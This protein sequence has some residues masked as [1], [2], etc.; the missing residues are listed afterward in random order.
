MGA[1]NWMPMSFSPLTGLVYIPAMHFPGL[2]KSN[3]ENLVGGVDI[4]LYYA[5]DSDEPYRGELLAWDPVGQQERWRRTIG[6]PYQGGTMVTAGGLVFQGTTKGAFHAYDAKSGKELWSFSTG[7]AVLGAPSTVEIDG[8]QMIF[9]AVGTGTTA[10][11][12][13]APD[14]AD[15]A[16]G[17]ARLLAFS[18][19]GSASLPVEKREPKKLAEPAVGE[20]APALAAK[21]KLI[22]DANGCELCHG[23]QAIGGIGSFPS[24]ERVPALDPI[25]FLAIVRHGVFTASGMPEF[26]DHIREEDVPALQAYITQQIWRQYRAQQAAIK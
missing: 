6:R 14:L 13:F 24:M 9:I 21:G 23:V 4:D 7:S 5:R 18:L 25:A 16:D 10:A 3:P 20:P 22:W 17:P 2:M 11:V 26:A 15:R 12:A 19:E 1:H 8:K